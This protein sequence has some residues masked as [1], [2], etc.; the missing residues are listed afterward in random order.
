M[1][2]SQWLNH[3]SCSLAECQNILVLVKRLRLK[4]SHG[5]KS[6]PPPL[7]IDS[8]VVSG[9]RL[10]DSFVP[11]DFPWNANSH[12]TP[13]PSDSKELSQSSTKVLTTGKLSLRG[14]R[15]TPPPQFVHSLYRLKIYSGQDS[16][17]LS[18]QLA[19]SRITSRSISTTSNNKN[20]PSSRLLNITHT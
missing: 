1:C 19:L 14:S 18:F 6:F 7:L 16:E 15:P 8:Y 2:S 4:M 11:S 9:L 10:I 3:L 5:S 13:A 20:Q 17:S 12:F